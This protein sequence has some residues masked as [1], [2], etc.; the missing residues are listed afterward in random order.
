MSIWTRGHLAKNTQL[1]FGGPFVKAH[2]I[3][4]MHFKK[5]HIKE[6]YQKASF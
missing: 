1:T 5:M 4:Y 3:D 6:M 2:E